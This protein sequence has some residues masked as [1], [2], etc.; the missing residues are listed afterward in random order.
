MESQT[1]FRFKIVVV[2][3]DGV[4]K[5]LM[6]QQAVGE[7]NCQQN[8]DPNYYHK[9]LYLKKT[10]FIDT[11]IELYI[12]DIEGSGQDMDPRTA[13]AVIVMYDITRWST[14]EQAKTRIGEIKGNTET[15]ASIT[16]IV[17]NKS[18]LEDRRQGK[19]TQMLRR[20]TI[21]FFFF[22]VSMNAGLL[23]AEENGLLFKEISSTFNRDA[24]GLFEDIAF[25]LYVS[26]VVPNLI[27]FQDNP[28]STD[29]DGYIG[30]DTD[31]DDN[32]SRIG[33]GLSVDDSYSISKLVG[34]LG[35]GLGM[36]M[37]LKYIFFN[38][39]YHS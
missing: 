14:F 10:K 5:T 3:D 19:N 12:L 32:H 15:V 21:K 22:K 38:V 16:L 31:T 33:T 26:R 2:G 39:Q 7:D 6:V 36:G 28:H 9:N 20:K 13:D 30:F 17:G 18:D 29:D 23:F 4:G 24:L 34:L 37:G 11:R 35:L 25:E 1:S 27:P 8:L